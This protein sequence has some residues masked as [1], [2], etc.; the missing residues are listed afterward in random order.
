MA[1]I[2][3]MDRMAKETLEN[4]MAVSI[5]GNCY[6][7]ALALHRDI[8]CKLIGVT[9]GETIVHAGVLLPD[10]KIYDGRGEITAE[11]FLRPFKAENRRVVA[12]VTEEALIASGKVSEY[13]I[14]FYLC[15][16]RIL[17]PDLPWKTKTKSAE[18]LDFLEE[19]EELCKRH[20]VWIR[21]SLSSAKPVLCEYQGDE[22]YFAE[23]CIDGINFLF[24]R[25]LSG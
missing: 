13:K 6:D 14:E 5:Y 8:D 17:W 24:D 3:E 10:G 2:T 18:I 12:G 4:S 16:A 23:P 11:E 1:E 20:K 9:D 21:S 22:S 25:A 15:R 7:L 19:L